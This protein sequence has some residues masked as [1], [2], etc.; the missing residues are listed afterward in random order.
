VPSSALTRLGADSLSGGL[1]LQLYRRGG[2]MWLSETVCLL[3]GWRRRRGS[4]AAAGQSDG[5]AG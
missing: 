1:R 5:G 4:A 3:S 2:E